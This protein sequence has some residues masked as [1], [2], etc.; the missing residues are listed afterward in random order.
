MNP[1]RGYL[2]SQPLTLHFGLGG[3]TVVDSVTVVWPDGARQQLTR[4]PVNQQVVIQQSAVPPS[5]SSVVTAKVPPA[6][7]AEVEPALPHTHEGYV[8]ND[9][10]RQPLMLWMYSHTGPV[11]A[12]GDV[13]KDGLDDLFISG[14][15]KKQGS[16]WVQQKGARSGGAFKKV[17]G[18]TIGNEEISAVSA[19]C[20]FDANGD[21]YDDLY[22]AKG[23][24]S[25]FE[26]NTPSLQ[27]E[28]YVNDGRGN[29]SLSKQPLPNVSASSKACVRPADYD[30]DGDLDLFVGGRIVRGRYP[31]TPRSYLLQ[32]ICKSQFSVV[33]TPFSTVGMVTDAQWTDVDGDGRPDLIFVGEFM[34]VKVYQNTKAGF[35]D[36]TAQYFAD[37]ERGFWQSLTVTDVNGDGRPDLIAGNLGTN[38]QIKFS[39]QE[40]A[41]L[42]YAD[43]DG[44]GSVDPFFCFSVQGKPYPFVSRD[45][46]NDQIYAMRKRFGFYK[47]YADATIGNI[48]PAD[49]LA[50]AKKLTVTECHTVC[51]LNRGGQFE[52][53]NLPIQAQFAPVTHIRTGDF[54]QDGRIDLLLFGN[55]S[56]NRL[57]LGSMDANYGCLLT[58]DGKGGFMYVSQPKSGLSVVGDVKSVLELGVGG[59]KQW[60]IGAF[61]QP[62]QVYHQAGS[63]SARP[64]P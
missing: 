41:E 56:D 36:Q 25:L 20:F 46:L 4:V 64:K 6:L 43:F 23:G 17:D 52:K 54:N 28:L 1:V 14:D 42:Y 62:L 10:K 47:D 58:G 19:A 29:L 40:P 50:G 3:A 31:E 8:E 7:F 38:S 32:S 30:G 45:E 63:P 35:V 55:R 48:F 26:P 59:Q 37:D 22:V 49:A 39:K 21:G 51:F 61:G 27:D 33:E 34:P 18:L 11:L 24:Y 15:Q 44:N 13:N 57:K 16:V 53:K 9:F 5:A 60:V 12:K 2:S